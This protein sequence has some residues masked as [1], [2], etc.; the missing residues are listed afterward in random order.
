MKLI[1]CHF[2]TKEIKYL[3]HIFSITGIRLLPLK[4]QAI[5]NMYPPNTVKQVCAFLRLAGYYRKFIKDF[6]KMAKPLT[7]LTCQRAKF[8]LTPVHHTT[9]LT[10]KMQLHKHLSCA[11]L[12]QQNDTQYTQMQQTMHVEYNY[13][14]NRM[15]WNF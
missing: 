5:N 10:L 11:T 15:E 7:L 9:F 13:Q 2:F 1:K 3:G 6:V 4:T 14:K 12:T 8:E